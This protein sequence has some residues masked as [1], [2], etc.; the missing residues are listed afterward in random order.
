M[1]G[2]LTGMIEND[3]F[4]SFYSRHPFTLSS[5]P[6]DDDHIGLHIRAVGEWTNRLLNFFEKEQERL[7][8]GEVPAY[9]DQTNDASDG[10]LHVVEAYV[11]NDK[12][13]ERSDGKT[14]QKN[15]LMSNVKIDVRT[16]MKS[17]MEKAMSMPDMENKIK[18][19]RMKKYS[20]QRHASKTNI[21]T[22][23][24]FLA[25]AI[26]HAPSLKSLSTTNR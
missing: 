3:A 14:M 6:E 26:I 11:T 23:Q 15:I 13:D 16:S 10:K 20:H 17:P 25:F 9:D 22:T 2:L 7:H 1:V 21:L 8:S 19:D 4:T 12:I 5:A 24:L 18:L